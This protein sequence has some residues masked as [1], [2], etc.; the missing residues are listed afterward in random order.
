M[1]NI[2]DH[3]RFLL[4]VQIHDGPWEINDC[5]KWLEDTLNAFEENR[6][7]LENAIDCIALEK[8]T[9]LLTER[10]KVLKT[11]HEAAYEARL[12]AEDHDLDINS[13][14]FKSMHIENMARNVRL[15]RSKLNIVEEEEEEMVWEPQIMFPVGNRF[16]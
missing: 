7:S 10:I 13:M 3:S 15:L 4:E 9:R 8:E 14:I 12:E 5:A 16:R 11:R 6:R 1:S 2:R